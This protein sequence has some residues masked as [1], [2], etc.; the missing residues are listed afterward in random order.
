MSISMSVSGGTSPCGSLNPKKTSFQEEDLCLYFGKFR[1]K[2]D[3]SKETNT[4]SPGSSSNV[5]PPKPQQQQSEAYCYP[6]HEIG[7]G[8]SHSA[9]VPLYSQDIWRGQS[10]NA[11]GK[12]FITYGSC[13]RFVCVCVRTHVFVTV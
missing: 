3:D 8:N 13:E 11:A 10:D 9:P 4:S 2:M 7:F 1:V 5:S 6:K 12:P